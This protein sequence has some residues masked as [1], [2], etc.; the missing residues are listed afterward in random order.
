MLCALA[1]AC[2]LAASFHAAYAAPGS[3]MPQVSDSEKVLLFGGFAAA[4][5]CV[6]VFLARDVIL[7]KKTA[8]DMEEME[9]KRDRT[10]EKYHSA[11]GDDYEEVGRRGNTPQ[12][13]EFSRAAR[14][15]TLPDYYGMLGVDPG[16]TPAEIKRSFREMA[17]RAHPDRSGGRSEG[18]MAGLNRAYEVLSDAE[19][20]ARYD[21]HLRAGR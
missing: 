10:F 9:S 16:A 15:G 18:E 4:T 3:M 5:A 17:K 2:L 6:I 8:Y 12:D 11:W 13:R 14:E 19:S 7:R 1:A 20:R 21:R